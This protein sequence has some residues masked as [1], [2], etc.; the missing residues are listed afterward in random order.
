MPGGRATFRRLQAEFVTGVYASLL[1]KP[2]TFFLDKTPRYYYIAEEVAE[3]FPDARFIVLLRS[4]LGVVA[5]NIALHGMRGVPVYQE[6]WIQGSKLL[7]AAATSLGS[8][9]IVVRFEDL[10]D[11]PVAIAGRVWKFLDLTWS[12]ELI[13]QYREQDLRNDRGDPIGPRVYSEV[14]RDPLT[15]WKNELADVVR[16]R[17]AQ[18]AIAHWDELY[19]QLGSYSRPELLVQLQGA[20][21][22]GGHNTRDLVDYV[23]GQVWRNG[24]RPLLKGWEAGRWDD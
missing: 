24:V 18:H 21:R 8:R 6:D 19:L 17:V 1:R 23:G 14:S 22:R 7:A 5:S 2:A 9:A 16:R 15:K 3:I 12:S 11:D 20:T 13:S 4:P 10:L